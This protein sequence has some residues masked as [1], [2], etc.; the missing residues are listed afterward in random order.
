MPDNES[1]ANRPAPDGAQ[2]RLSAWNRPAPDVEGRSPCRF[3]SSASAGLHARAGRAA[4][5]RRLAF[6]R[7][8]IR[9]APRRCLAVRIRASSGC[10]ATLGASLSS[11]RFRSLRWRKWSR[12]RA[13]GF[14][15]TDLVRARVWTTHRYAAHGAAS[16]PRPRTEEKNPALDTPIGAGNCE[17]RDPCVVHTR[18]SEPAPTG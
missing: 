6:D 9:R 17:P 10:S 11:A 7:R 3:T 18:R 14:F 2:S 12:P 13:G 1:A 5:P 4:P 15:T 8:A 16:S